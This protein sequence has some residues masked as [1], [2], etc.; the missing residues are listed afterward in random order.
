MGIPS[1]ILGVI[2]FL[3]FP[4]IALG[5]QSALSY[6]QKVLLDVLSIDST[7]FTQNY[8]T[9]IGLLFSILAGQTYYFM[10]QQQESV[11]YSLFKEVTEAK[12]LL[13]QV[14]L[15]CQGRS[16]YPKALSS[17]NRY[18]QDDLKQLQADPSKM[19]SSRPMDDPLESIM[20]MT[21]VG[22]PSSVYDTVR[23]LRQ[24]RA[25]RLG[26]LQRKLPKLHNLMLWI[27]AAMELM[28]FPLLGAGTETIGGIRNLTVE[29]VLFGIATTG[30]AMTLNVIAEMYSPA[31]GA[32]NVDNVLNVMVRGLDEEL[33]VRMENC[34]VSRVQSYNA[35]NVNTASAT[36]FSN[37]TTFYAAT[38]EE[39]DSNQNNSKANTKPKSRVKRLLRWCVSWLD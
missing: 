6:D 20:Y 34:Q 3:A 38:F 33:N 22:V 39:T 1:A 37:T 17:I 35:L 7:Q 8:V 13:E 18:V 23:S 32:Y 24:A 4:Y 16:L 28:S 29:G 10:Y 11:Y 26:S 25:S 14:A 27:L 12:S 5:L 31:G 19:L 21:S 15:A 2:A 9:V 36:P 30:I